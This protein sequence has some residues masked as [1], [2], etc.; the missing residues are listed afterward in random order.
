MKKSI[1]TAITIGMASGLLLTGCGAQFPEMTEE[2]YDQ[3]VQYSV[4]LLLKYS[5]NGVER[6]S[7]LSAL[8]LQKQIEKEN[9]EAAK[10]AR[11]AENAQNI[12]N[13][14]ELTDEENPE[15][16]TDFAMAE[17]SSETP[18][19][20]TDD[21]SE[22]DMEVPPEDGSGKIDEQTPQ[23]E[24]PS[25]DQNTEDK[26]GDS[27]DDI[28]KLLE[29]YE[30]DLQEGID[31]ASTEED[32]SDTGKTAEGDETPEGDETSKPEDDS[33]SDTIPIPDASEGDSLVTQTDTVVDG[34][35]QEIS[36]GIFLTY[37]GYSVNSSY[38]D[39]SEVFAITATEG[40]KLLILNFK[41]INTSGMDVSVDMAK[42]NP[43]FQIILNGKNVGYTNVT[44]LQDDLSTYTGTIPAGAKLNMVLVKQMKADNVKTVDSLGLIGDLK[45]ETITFNL[46]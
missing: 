5:N 24:L 17:D 39:E 26:S 32:S 19:E 3:I 22:D 28:D 10:A 21:G 34:M 29:K 42:A 46:E 43:H 37:S 9:R 16:T 45:G 12:A 13:A 41:L 30:D 15:E 36:K 7:S 18:E 14:A 44:M 4:N 8:E 1:L 25:D 11:D 6:L 31:N 40:N 23:E 20:V 33:G 35:R 38:A 27:E 2:E